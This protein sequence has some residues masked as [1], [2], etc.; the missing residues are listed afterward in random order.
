MRHFNTITGSLALFSRQPITAAIYLK[1]Y[2]RS[3]LASNTFG[4][5]TGQSS[6]G[7][8]AGVVVWSSES[9]P[10]W[11]NRDP[12][13]LLMRATIMKW[14]SYIRLPR[15]LWT[16]VSTF[17][18]PRK[19]RDPS[20]DRRFS[21]WTI[22]AWRITVLLVWRPRIPTSRQA[23]V[24]PEQ[25]GPRADRQQ[26]WMRLRWRFVPR[27]VGTLPLSPARLLPMTIVCHLD[28]AS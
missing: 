7:L 22:S 24:A 27:S 9:T 2:H 16:S 3:R 20:S 26:G 23:S 21:P 15:T 19:V 6:D 28:N 10:S 11:S 18:A 1:H 13:L 14:H 12:Y 5:I 8:A 25:S 4:S 17:G